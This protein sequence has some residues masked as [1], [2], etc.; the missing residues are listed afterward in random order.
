MNESSALESRLIA[1]E[2]QLMQLQ[3][4]FE[5]LNAECLHQRQLIQQQQRRLEYL[6]GQVRALTGGGTPSS[7]QVEE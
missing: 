3:Y 1:I 4:D 5:Q 6:E 7:S 2:M